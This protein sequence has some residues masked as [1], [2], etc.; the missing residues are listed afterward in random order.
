MEASGPA[1]AALEE[2]LGILLRRHNN[3]CKGPRLAMAPQQRDK[4][5]L[6]YIYLNPQQ[7]E[8]SCKIACRCPR[9]ARVAL[10]SGSIGSIITQCPLGGCA[11][12]VSMSTFM[13]YI[14]HHQI[15]SRWT[16]A[17]RT[18]A[19]SP[20]FRPTIILFRNHVAKKPPLLRR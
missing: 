15:R 17:D 19:M 9:L 4:F 1:F 8:T 20:I 2:C 3:H 6:A 10:L 13:I 18:W 7:E 16:A 12:R 5:P 14:I 11:C